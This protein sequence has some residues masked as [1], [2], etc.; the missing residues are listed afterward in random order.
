[1]SENTRE[2]TINEMS[3]IA[4]GAG[5][6]CTI[7]VV[8][9]GDTLTKIARHFGVSVDDIVRWNGIKDRNLIITGQRLKIYQ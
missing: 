7:Y 2:L 9:R 4:G 1:M 8:Q 5:G 3:E 6:K